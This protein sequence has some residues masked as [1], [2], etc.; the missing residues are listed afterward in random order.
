MLS[1][2]FILCVKKNTYHAII[3]RLQSPFMY[4]QLR[5]LSMR[6]L[7]WGARDTLITERDGGEEGKGKK[8]EEEIVFVTSPFP[9]LCYLF[10]SPVFLSFLLSSPSIHQYK[11]SG[12]QGMRG[13]TFR[14]VPTLT[15]PRAAR[16]ST[17]ISCTNARG[18]GKPCWRMPR[19]RELFMCKYPG[20][21]RG[22][23]T[24]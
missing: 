17:K 8:R 14:S 24:Q 18:P 12:T 11:G 3:K 2:C 1:L 10:L 22:D 21:S 7:P 6:S 9:P 15:I 23:R 4:F 5:C 19:G 20:V 13:L 16:G